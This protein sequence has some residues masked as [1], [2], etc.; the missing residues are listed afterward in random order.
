MRRALRG[1]F[2]KGVDHGE[3]LKEAEALRSERRKGV[4]CEKFTQLQLSFAML[5]EEY[6]QVLAQLDLLKDAPVDAPARPL[7]STP[8]SEIGELQLGES[9]L[10]DIEEALS[11]VDDLLG[12][13]EWLSDDD[14][15]AHDVA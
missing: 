5:Q 7:S 6:A 1:A 13:L 12:C 14:D 2:E 4:D 15:G 9:S 3:W 8:V 10:G 11:H